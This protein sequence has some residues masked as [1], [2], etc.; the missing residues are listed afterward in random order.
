MQGMDIAEK[1]IADQ[2]DL[3]EELAESYRRLLSNLRSYRPYLTAALFA[4]RVDP[5]ED[6]AQ[7]S[8]SLNPFELH[9]PPDEI[10]PDF[11]DPH[12]T[13]MDRMSELRLV[14]R[15]CSLLRAG[16]VVDERDLSDEERVTSIV[17]T[18]V[19]VMLQGSESHKGVL[20]TLGADHMLVGWNTHGPLATH[21]YFGVICAMHV[22]GEL[23]TLLPAAPV[24]LAVCCGAAFVGTAG[25][26]DTHIAPVVAGALF[27]LS[28]ELARLPALLGA[29]CICEDGAYEQTRSEVVARVVDVVCL[30]GRES[31]VY[32]LLGRKADCVGGMSTDEEGIQRY[33]SAFSHMRQL[34]C[35]RAK[36]L[37]MDQLR[38]FPRDTQALRLL[39]LCVLLEKTP[40]RNTSNYV[41]EWR[42][43][44]AYE[45]RGNV[46]L[47]AEVE[48]L[49]QMQVRSMEG[50]SYFQPSPTAAWPSASGISGSQTS[51]SGSGA[52]GASI[53][54]NINDDE[55]AIKQAIEDNRRRSSDDDKEDALPRELTDQQGRKYFRA[56]IT[57]GKGAYGEVYIGMAGNG[58][59]VA[60]K[61]LELPESLT[62]P[63]RGMIQ[64]PVVL[65]PGGL[66][67]F[68]SDVDKE[69]EK[70]SSTL[71]RSTVLQDLLK[72]V[73]L[74]CGLRHDN[75]VSYLGTAVSRGHLIVVLEYVP[76]GSL[77]SLV[78]NFGGKIP[79]S[80]VQRYLGDTMNGLE[81]LHTKGVV[82]RDLKPHNVL[83]AADGTGK[84][85]DFGASEEL[86]K[87]RGIEPRAAVTG[88]PHYMSPEQCRGEAEEASDVW[89]L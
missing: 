85:A 27:S 6:S 19:T 38:D 12:L 1:A 16:L 57:I 63:K 10:A 66:F 84:L 18:F 67:P 25:S 74:M 52:M 35:D 41:R 21:A 29:G 64:S 81:Y 43:W 71:Q 17:S 20:L 45:L 61:A 88:T 82:H 22:H 39:K 37:L 3:P 68:A 79:L 2:G 78:A 47:P 46:E 24:G 49:E 48:E 62:G 56:N 59:L 86:H 76:G 7:L 58:G 50:L 36:K 26:Q 31:F 8:H 60:L 13:P 4:P 69:E 42:G 89:S 40:P 72:E 5:L 73:S 53:P 15:R 9:S 28:V 34:R 87:L 32:E 80:S 14:K 11:P 23:R 65:P 55:S 30:R 75:I 70:E 33:T 77:H 51:V 54:V 83:V 44:G